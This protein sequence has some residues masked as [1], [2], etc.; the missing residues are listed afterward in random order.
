MIS[1]CYQTVGCNEVLR[2]MNKFVVGKY[3]MTNEYENVG[4]KRTHLI[5]HMPLSI[6]KHMIQETSKFLFVAIWN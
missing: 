1:A 4:G 2:R 5:N 3:F 6:L